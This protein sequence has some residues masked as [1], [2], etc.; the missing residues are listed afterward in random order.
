MMEEKDEDEA[1]QENMM[2]VTEIQQLGG[3]R[4]EFT[5][6]CLLIAR[7]SRASLSLAWRLIAKMN[8]EEVQQRSDKDQSTYLH[9]IVNQVHSHLASTG[10]FCYRRFIVIIVINP[11]A[12]RVLINKEPITTTTTS[13]TVL[14][15]VK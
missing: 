9:L 12:V 1:E 5:E 15:T 14:Q 4:F 7:C 2:S 13:T 11:A 6:L 10:T 8:D 3:S